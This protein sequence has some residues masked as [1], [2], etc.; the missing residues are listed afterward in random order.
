MPNLN[1]LKRHTSMSFVSPEF[2][3]VALIFYSLYWLLRPYRQAQMMLLLV[4]SYLLYATWSVQ[5][6]LILFLFSS[7]V[8][9]AG[10]WL[11]SLQAGRRR[12]VCFGLGIVASLLLLFTT[13]YYSFSRDILVGLFPSLGHSHLLPILDFAAPA[14]ISFFTF[15]AITYLV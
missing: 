12:I 11:S 14:G 5:F 2:A 6:A 3:F 8:W 15:Q 1:G 9:L 13:K 10:W 4:S 7:Y